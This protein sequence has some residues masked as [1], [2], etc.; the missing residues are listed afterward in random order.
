VLS[1]G[2]KKYPTLPFTERESD[3]MRGTWTLDAETVTLRNDGKAGAFKVRHLD[4]AVHDE[5]MTG[6]DFPAYFTTTRGTQR[7]N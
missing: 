1:E 2:D 3:G 4:V 7:G 6:L 5:S